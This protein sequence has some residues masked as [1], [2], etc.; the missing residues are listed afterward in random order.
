M[1]PEYLPNCCTEFLYHIITKILK[2]NTLEFIQNFLSASYSKKKSSDFKNKSFRGL[3][4]STASRI[5]V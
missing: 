4:S 1:A 5:L 3:V 2:V